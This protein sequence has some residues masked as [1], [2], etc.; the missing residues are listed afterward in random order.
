M[1]KQRNIKEPNP[2]NFFGV[3]QV[4][5]PPPHFEILTIGR[6]LYNLEGT[7]I[8][9][10]TEHLKGRF[11]VG[12]ST[13]LDESNQFQKVIKVGFEDPKELSYFSLACPYL[14]YK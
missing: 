9:W 8:K 10:I 6:Q 12:H 11:Y 1:S 5:I 3:R 7:I 13:I 2:L 14:K 4:R